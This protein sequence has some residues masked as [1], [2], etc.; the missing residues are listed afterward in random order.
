MIKP[1]LW[2]GK[3]LKG[4]WLFTRK[5]D[6][7][8]M[9]RDK[10]GLP[11][12]RRDKP[13]YNLNDI[14]D[15]ITDC[16]IFI[17]NWETSVSAVRTHKGD[18]VSPEHAYSIDP[19]DDRLILFTLTNPTAAKINALLATALSI[20]D[21]GLVLYQG[22]KSLKV[23]PVE[24]YDVP[25]TGATEGK[26]KY[27]GLIGAL[28]TPKGKVS[29]MSDEQR[30]AFTRKLPEVIEVSCMGLTKNGKFRHPRFERERFDKEIP[31]T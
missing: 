9:L 15:H 4:D 14:P 12:S 10:H 23:K 26:G 29:G 19:L 30:R 2:S 5:L 22:K 25:V 11:V 20:G 6:G 28:I 7:V 24:N 3:D 1:T 21:E 27:A 16:E 13:L 17:D 31:H 18:M 8:R